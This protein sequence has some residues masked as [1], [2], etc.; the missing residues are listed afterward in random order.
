MRTIVMGATHVTD[1]HVADEGS[2][3]LSGSNS[4]AFCLTTTAATAT[5]PTKVFFEELHILMRTEDG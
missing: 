5:S 1:E 2:T 4:P 3:A